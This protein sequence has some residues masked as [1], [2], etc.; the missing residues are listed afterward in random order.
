MPFSVVACGE[1]DLVVRSAE[2]NHLADTIPEVVIGRL[3]QVVDRVTTDIHRAGCDFVQMRFP[4]VGAGAFDK[5][6]LGLPAPAYAVAQLGCQFE[7]CRSTSD[8]DNVME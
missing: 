8:N 4:D 5:G 2:A 1:M 6:D 3:S 7:T